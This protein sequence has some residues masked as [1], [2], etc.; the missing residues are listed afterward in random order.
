MIYREYR[1]AVKRRWTPILVPETE[2]INYTGFVSVYGF[3]EETKNYVEE[4]GSTR[5]L[6]GQKLYSSTLFLDIDHNDSLAD[7]IQRSLVDRQVE[8]Y[9]YHTGGKGWHF[10]IPIDPM[11]GIDVPWRQK[12]WVE[13]TFPGT[14]L[15][16]YNTAGMIRLPGTFHHKNPGKFKVLVD[17]APGAVLKIGHTEAKVIMGS[18]PEEEYET[19]AAL[20][21]LL[22]RRLPDGT[23]TKGMYLRAMMC[24]NLDLPEDETRSLLI[25]YNSLLVD[26]A[27]RDHEFEKIINS[28]YY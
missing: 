18:M 23:R 16:I 11:A 5:G 24:K 3:N 20:D 9:K 10:H 21:N 26:P 7:E 6:R 27:L 28:V 4:T 12:R 13:Q 1:P 17:S 2:L 25:K 15:A 19:Q 8:W 22:M 14:D